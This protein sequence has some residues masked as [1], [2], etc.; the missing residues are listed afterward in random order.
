MQKKYQKIIMLGAVGLLLAASCEKTNDSHVSVSESNSNI[1]E[2]SLGQIAEPEDSGEKPRQLAEPVSQARQ[3]VLKK[4]FAL[5]VSPQNSPVSPEKFSGYHT[6]TDFEILEG[7][8]DLDVEVFSVCSGKVLSK[9]TASRYGGVLVQSCQ[10]DGQDVTVVY[11]HLRLSSINFK[12][13]DSL[14]A[15]G[16]LGV[17]GT[18]YSSET[19]GERKH[20]HL[21]IHKGKAV[22][23]LGYS[24]NKAGLADWLNVLDYLK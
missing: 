10:L 1:A 11:G 20:L 13:G 18:G 15:G 22:N 7:E 14:E 6:G 16:K 19:D 12:V 17:L 5:Q 24:K 2:Q 9:R 21:G 23:I 8:Q 3:R 4:P